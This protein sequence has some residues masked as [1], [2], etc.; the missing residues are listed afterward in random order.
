M[1]NFNKFKIGMRTIKTG[2]AVSISMFIATLM[3]LKSPIFVGIGAIMAMQSSV[4]ESFNAGINRM[5][6]T[7]VGALVGLIFSFIFPQNFIF[8]GIGIII[9]IHIHYIFNWKKSLTLSA[10]VFMAIFLNSENA[11]IPYAINRIIDTFIGIAVAVLVNYFIFAPNNKTNL[12]LSLKQ[13]Y[14]SS[15]SMVYDFVRGRDISLIDLKSQVNLIRE[16]NIK[17]KEDMDLNFYKTAKTELINTILSIMDDIYMEIKNIAKLQKESTINEENLALLQKLSL[18][19]N[20]DNFDEINDLD[21][22]YNFHL[23]N[24]LNN[25]IEIEDLLEKVMT[26]FGASH[27][28]RS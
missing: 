4:S 22:V 21:I 14:K 8:L 25:L 12:L 10:I 11:R 24:I 27:Q 18:Q 28:N 9:V 13:L 7:I 3:N 2:L 1:I 19:I 26:N 6:G 17:L 15:K 5:L 16:S 20:H 23:N